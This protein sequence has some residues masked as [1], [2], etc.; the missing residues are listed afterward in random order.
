MFDPIILD[1]LEMPSQVLFLFLFL[2]LFLFHDNFQWRSKA[3]KV[4]LTGQF[5]NKRQTVQIMSQYSER[6]NGVRLMKNYLGFY[7]ED[8]L[9]L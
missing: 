4:N 2:L 1:I 7:K 6:V 5:L 3:D 8:W 9:S